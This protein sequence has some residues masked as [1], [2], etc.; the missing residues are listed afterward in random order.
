MTKEKLKR[1]GLLISFLILLSAGCTSQQNTVEKAENKEEPV[2][3]T[4]LQEE[5]KT[6]E[7][8]ESTDEEISSD[9]EDSIDDVEKGIYK[10]GVYEG[11]HKSIGVNVT[12]EKSKISNIEI[13]KNKQTKGYYEEVFRRLPKEI[14]EKQSID[15]EGVSGSTSTSKNLKEAINIALSKAKGEKYN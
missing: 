7:S 15:V 6:I 5:N 12:I 13:T 2:N 10:D 1:I 8:G 4:V 3:E 11:V 9:S 14:I